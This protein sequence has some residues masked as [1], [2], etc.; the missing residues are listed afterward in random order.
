MSTIA[1]IIPQ[2]P[3]APP[4]QTSL[5]AGPFWP[6]ISLELVRTNVAVDGSVTTQRLE[7]AATAALG[8]VID[9]LAAW[10]AEQQ[11][12]GC[13]TLASVPAVHINGKSLQVVRFERAVYAYAKA[14]LAERYADADATGRAERG[15]DGR[16]VQA[17]EYRRDALHAV[18]DILGQPRMT[19]EL[20]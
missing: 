19:S 7:H 13:A 10:A 20:I 12:N 17:D 9:Q 18:R 8:N 15:E 1:I 11:A 5:D 14:D 6:V 16:R 2:Q 3:A 4:Q